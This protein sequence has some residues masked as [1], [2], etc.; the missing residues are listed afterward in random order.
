MTAKV[1]MRY[2]AHNVLVEH[3]DGGYI[4]CFKYNQVQCDFDIFAEDQLELA[5][6]YMISELPS[7]EYKV[8]ASDGSQIL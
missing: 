3:T 4:R 5:A 7:V 6:D 8:T 1:L 2:P